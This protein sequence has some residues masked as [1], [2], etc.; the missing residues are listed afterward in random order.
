MADAALQAA[1]LEELDWDPEVEA[2]EYNVAVE[3]GVVTLTGVVDRY[4]KR[5]AAERAV[6]RVAGVRAVANDL[7]VRSSGVRTD[8]DIAAAAADR[9]A[10]DGLPPEAIEI[11]VA[12][13]RVTV[14]GE[15]DWQFQRRAAEH[16]VQRVK[17][18]RAVHNQIAVRQPEAAAAHIAAGIERAL[19]RNGEVDAR[20]IV[21][22][23][24]DGQATLTGDVCSRA[25]Q[26]AA[27]AIAWRAPGV[28]TSATCCGP[29]A[30]PMR[31]PHGPA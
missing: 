11:T 3:R 24:K 27:A 9:I 28:S 6:Q 22:A 26:E 5:L 31:R 19:S 7:V 15:V 1:V 30:T 13:G 25:E 17:G 2:I 10:A 20:Q 23:V 14:A 18:V 21:V 16:A 29:S 4:A 8:A 12:D